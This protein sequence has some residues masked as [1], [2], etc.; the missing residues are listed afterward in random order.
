ML[1]VPLKEVAVR[2][3]LEGAYATVHFEMIY[4]NPSDHSIECSYEFPPEAET[5]LS[6]L[7]VTTEDKVIEAKVEAKE[8]AQE[9]YE[10]I[11]AGGNLGV[12]AERKSG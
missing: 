4:V 10:D 12:Y 8:K 5:L 6:K 2:A 1:M 3:T 7:I 11:L 9:K